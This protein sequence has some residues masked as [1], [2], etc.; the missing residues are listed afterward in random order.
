[1]GCISRF[2]VFAVDFNGEKQEIHRCG[3]DREVVSKRER[4][5]AD[6]LNF[7]FVAIGWILFRSPHI[8]DAWGY[9][10]EIFAPG[11]LLGIDIPR[12]AI[13]FVLLMLL[14][15]WIQRNKEHGLALE[16]V[17]NGVVRYACYLGLL[18]VIF[19]FGV[20]NETFIYFQF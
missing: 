2:A 19:V 14:V 10:T 7:R 17:R 15:E 4:I 8:T 11:F 6:G 9:F 13:A 3:G 18:V 20:F 5:I 1:M 16:G 12:K